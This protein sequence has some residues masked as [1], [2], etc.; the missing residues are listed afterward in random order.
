MYVTNSANKLDVIIL[1]SWVQ[2]LSRALF[3]SVAYYAYKTDNTSLL[4]LLHYH[5]VVL[6]TAVH[7]VIPLHNLLII[8]SVALSLPLLSE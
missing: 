1:S 4:V 6:P 3:I 7:S 8:D 2:L 5:Y